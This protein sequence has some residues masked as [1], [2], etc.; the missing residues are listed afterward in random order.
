MHSPVWLV[1]GASGG[2][3][4]ALALRI[5]RSGHCVIGAVRSKTRAS[6]AVQQIEQA[7]GSVIEIDM[8]ES[9]SSITSKIQSVGKIDYL[10]NNAGYSILA[11]CEDIRYALDR[12]ANALLE[13]N[14]SK[15]PTL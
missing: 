10:V 15:N 9:K 12:L 5:L 8:T 13:T 7:G 1:T 6:E 4:L 14:Q 2:L 11:P 3:G